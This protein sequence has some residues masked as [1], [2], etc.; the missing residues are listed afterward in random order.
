MDENKKG[1]KDNRKPE[2]KIKKPGVTSAHTTPAKPKRPF[3][4]VAN[5]SAEELALLSHQIEEMSS[6]VKGVKDSVS[7][8]M[9]KDDMKV[10]IKSTV[11]E[12]MV[13]LYKGLELHIETKLEEHSKSFNK[14]IEDLKKEN[15][16][17]KI[18]N[19][20]LQ[21]KLKTAQN[22][23]DATEKRSQLAVKMANYNEQ[24]S[25]KNNI[26]ILNMKEDGEETETSL[27]SD[28][29]KLLSDKCAVDL[30]PREIQAIH[31]IPGKTGTPNP[32]LVKLFNNNSKTKIMKKRS[33]MKKAG[34]RLVDDV[35]KMH[36]KLISELLDHKSI[37]SAWYFNGSVFGRTTDGKRVK[38]DLYDDI[39]LAVTK[40]AAPPAAAAAPPPT[41]DGSMD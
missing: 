24:Y 23:V 4:E 1:I 10:F 5:S 14:T 17:L 11:E 33:D 8:I 19:N 28:V 13:E 20:S 9:T 38:F 39:D 27:T 2:E 15:E 41:P 21:T 36:A 26:K 7:K 30:N 34:H 6:E 35:T 29:C 12:I 32:V 22:Q 37:D 3:T 40:A 16:L 25:R 18:E 31:R